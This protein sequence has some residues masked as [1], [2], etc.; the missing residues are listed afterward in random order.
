MPNYYVYLGTDAGV[1][2]LRYPSLWGPKEIDLNEFGKVAYF[3][4]R[5]TAIVRFSIEAPTAEDA[6]FFVDTGI[7]GMAARC[8]LLSGLESVVFIE[9]APDNKEE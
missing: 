9:M 1:S 8:A 3:N 5:F 2:E 4:Y 7:R 6:K